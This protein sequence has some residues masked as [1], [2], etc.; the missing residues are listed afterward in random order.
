MLSGKG[1]FLNQN[2]GFEFYIELV[3]NMNFYIEFRKGKKKYDFIF[4]MLVV[5]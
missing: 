1:N 5:F 3:E 4:I 2:E